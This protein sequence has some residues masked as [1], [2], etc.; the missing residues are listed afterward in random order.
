MK[1]GDGKLYND[2][3]GGI[4]R[5]EKAYHCR[6]MYWT[7][8]HRKCIRATAAAGQLVPKQIGQHAGNGVETKHSLSTQLYKYLPRCPAYHDYIFSTQVKMICGLNMRQTQTL[9]KKYQET[10]SNFE[11]WHI[12]LIKE[13]NQIHNDYKGLKVLSQNKLDQFGHGYL[14]WNEIDR[15]LQ[16]WRKDFDE[17]KCIKKVSPIQASDYT[18]LLWTIYNN[19]VTRHGDFTDPTF[20]INNMK[21]LNFLQRELGFRLTID[22]IKVLIIKEWCDGGVDIDELLNVVKE[23]ETLSP[24]KLKA[25]K[26]ERKKDKHRVTYGNMN[27]YVKHMVTICCMKYTDQ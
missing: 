19:K 10:P 26:R 2:K 24:M 16:K 20:I 1:H 8:K 6:D 7:Q 18:A 11:T 4:N 25:T 23:Q 15:T 13:I 5:S 14:H 17:N 9:L 12:E 27:I 22:E 3:S 21:T